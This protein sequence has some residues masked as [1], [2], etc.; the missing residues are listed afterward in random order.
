MQAITRWH[1]GAKKV[2]PLLALLAAGLAAL[3]AVV[4]GVLGP[5]KVVHA[6]DVASPIEGENFDVRLTSTSVVTGTTL[7]SNGQALKT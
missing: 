7:Y 2:A 6:A 4:V 5:I 1:D 3:A